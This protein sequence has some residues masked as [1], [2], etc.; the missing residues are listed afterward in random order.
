MSKNLNKDD[1]IN[2]ANRVTHRVSRKN[3]SKKD[4]LLMIT[5]QKSKEIKSV[6]KLIYLK[7]ELFP[8]IERYC[9]GSFTGIINYLIRRGLDEVI[10]SGVK[11]LE[12]A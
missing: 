8:D 9:A 7:E 3:P 5:G 2:E 11:I 12:D 10:K 4:I 1:F 6:Q